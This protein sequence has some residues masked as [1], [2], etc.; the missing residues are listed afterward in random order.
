ME[1]LSV[2]DLAFFL[3][4]TKESPKHV[5]GLLIFQK[6]DDYAGDFVQDL[7]ALFLEKQPVHPFNSKV[8]MRLSGLPKW[9]EDKQL[10]MSYHV[11]HLAVPKNYTDEDFWNLMAML[12]ATHLDRSRP[13]WEACF[14]D[15][16]EGNRFAFYLKVHHACVDGAGYMARVVKS[17]SE[18]PLD[19]SV[20]PIWTISLSRKR[21]PDPLLQKLTETVSSLT[22]QI[23]T[24]PQ[25]STSVAKMGL[26]TLGL[27]KGKLP[28]PF[29]APKT[30]L[31]APVTRSR[32]IAAVTLSLPRVKCVAQASGA[33]VN[34]V[35]VTVCELALER[36]FEDTGTKKPAKPLVAQIPVSLRREGEAKSGNQIAVA[37]VE[38]THWGLSPLQRL[39]AISRS[40]SDV[41]EEFAAMSAEALTT[42][43][44]VLQG[45]AQLSDS[46]GMTGKLPPL[47]NLLVSNVPGPSKP[48]YLRGARLLSL[49][50]LSTIP[51]GMALNITVTSYVDQLQVGLIAGREIIQDL[52]G[53]AGH[54][55][56]C[57]HN[58]EQ[59][60]I[61]TKPPVKSSAKRTAG[62]KKTTTGGT[63]RKTAVQA[64]DAKENT[65]T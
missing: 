53:I 22:K 13:L 33:T 44:L 23:K 28:V 25:L 20:K 52:S 16:L 21:E 15:G 65:D 8:K 36:Y 31:N 26:E 30:L 39:K 2:L 57:F 17:L 5:A 12:H 10:E 45:L 4:E 19:D 1:T 37:L 60:V 18:N 47:G 3:T 24:I 50:P 64:K 63:R 55:D 32:R 56:A 38:L 14:I 40:C 9:K 59:A 54:I 35:V 34:D 46:A 58:L 49:Y 43:T 7:K 6:P 29:T 41:K 48:L 11:N 27:Y 62:R 61:E 51:P 42:Y